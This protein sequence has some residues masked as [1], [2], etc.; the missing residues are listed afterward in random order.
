MPDRGEVLGGRA[1][2][3]DHVP[4]HRRDQGDARKPGGFDHVEGGIDIPLAHDVDGRPKAHSAH[5]G[6]HAG[7]VEH[8][9]QHHRRAC[10]RTVLWLDLPAALAFVEQV[11]QSAHDLAERGCVGECTVA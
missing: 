2:G 11:L 9:R 5:D 3:M 6:Q 10:H 8:R 1:R 7:K 4:Q